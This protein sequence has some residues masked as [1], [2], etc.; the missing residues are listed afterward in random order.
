MI[1][2]GISG[3]FFTTFSTELVELLPVSNYDILTD[4]YQLLRFFAVQENYTTAGLA[5]KSV[6]E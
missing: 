3:E 5:A 2:W 1:S 6:K 4:R